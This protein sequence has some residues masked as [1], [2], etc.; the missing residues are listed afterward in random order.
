[1]LSNASSLAACLSAQTFARD[2]EG[3]GAA[4]NACHVTD[5][6][7][8]TTGELLRGLHNAS[9]RFYSLLAATLTR[10]IGLP[11]R[12]CSGRAFRLSE[13]SCWP[14]NAWYVSTR[15]GGTEIGA[16]NTI[17]VTCGSN[18]GKH[19]RP[20]QPPAAGAPPPST[21]GW[22]ASRGTRKTCAQK[23]ATRRGSPAPG[24]GLPYRSAGRT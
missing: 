19:T 23:A 24:R 15:L 10:F 14:R 6:S 11:F 18:A 21:A 16:S 20:A 5:E 2:R 3:T 22:S 12:G 7:T 17:Q 9:V 4:V 13:C 8:D 1:M